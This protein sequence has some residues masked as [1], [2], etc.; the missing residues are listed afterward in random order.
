MDVDGSV[1]LFHHFSRLF[2]PPYL[3]CVIGLALGSISVLFLPG[4]VLLQLLQPQFV[5]LQN[6]ESLLVID[7]FWMLHESQKSDQTVQGNWMPIYTKPLNLQIDS[8]LNVVIFR[9]FE[10]LEADDGPDYAF[11]IRSF[12]PE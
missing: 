4:K 2:T 5:S 9:R 12:R 11:V 3:F 7:F 10:S 1:Q 6:I 8:D